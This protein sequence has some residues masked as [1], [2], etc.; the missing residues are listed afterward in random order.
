M[1]EPEQPTRRMPLLRLLAAALAGGLGVFGVP[2]ATHASPPVARSA[3]PAAA[4]PD[5]R[6]S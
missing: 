4:A 1:D 3:P 5:V 6:P 2:A